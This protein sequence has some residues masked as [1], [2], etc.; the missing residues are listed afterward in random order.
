MAIHVSESGREYRTGEDR[1]D[2]TVRLRVSSAERARWERE[3]V[4]D[5]VA[6]SEWIRDAANVAASEEPAP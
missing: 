4:L 3:A 5:G 1:R 6:L 2:Q